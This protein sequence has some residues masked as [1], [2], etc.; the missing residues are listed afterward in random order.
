[1]ASLIEAKIFFKNNITECYLVPLEENNKNWIFYFIN[2]NYSNV[3]M[4]EKL[5]EPFY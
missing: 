5:L 4:L 1:M 3:Q 2:F